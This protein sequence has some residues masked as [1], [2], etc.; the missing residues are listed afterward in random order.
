MPRYLKCTYLL[1]NPVWSPDRFQTAPTLAQLSSKVLFHNL[2]KSEIRYMWLQSQWRCLTVA[3]CPV[4]ICPRRGI[5]HFMR[6][7]FQGRFHPDKWKSG[8]VSFC[9]IWLTHLSW[10]FVSS[11]TFFPQI[12]IKISAPRKLQL[13]GHFGK[14][15]HIQ[16][17]PIISNY[18]YIETLEPGLQKAFGTPVKSAPC[19]SRWKVIARWLVHWPSNTLIPCPPDSEAQLYLWPQLLYLTGRS[20]I[21]YEVSFLEYSKNIGIGL[22]D[23]NLHWIIPLNL[24][25]YMEAAYLGRKI[26]WTCTLVA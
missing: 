7:W 12:L 5:K 18:P 6:P 25:M 26:I 8:L 16:S 24:N 14:R 9:E 10:P 3:Y 4:D 1:L 22:Y 17:G 15:C 20:H 19:L 11:E 13:S 23:F 21:S 2:V